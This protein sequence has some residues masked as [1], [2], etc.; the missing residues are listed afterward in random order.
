MTNL[1]QCVVCLSLLLSCTGVSAQPLPKAFNAD[2]IGNA[3]NS[4]GP[5]DGIGTAIDLKP[6]KSG[7]KFMSVFVD[8]REV[9]ELQGTLQSTA[10]DLP[11]MTVYSCESEDRASCAYQTDSTASASVA[12]VSNN[13][14]KV[15]GVL[16]FK[17]NDGEWVDA[18][19]RVKISPP[20]GQAKS[21]P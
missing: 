21:C 11:H 2:F 1:T 17:N 16:R 6:R 4:C 7:G 15:E 13:H 14:G 9:E 8:G 3:F 10:K 5:T 19:F 18:S 20:P 12:I